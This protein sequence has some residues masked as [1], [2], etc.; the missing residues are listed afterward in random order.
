MA[1]A[2]PSD[3]KTEVK[4]GE[5]VTRKRRET[6]EPWSD[7]RFHPRIMSNDEREVGG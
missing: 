4:I 2:N 5:M 1:A 7:R 3:V 6:T